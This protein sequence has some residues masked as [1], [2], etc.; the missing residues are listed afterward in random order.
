MILYMDCIQY[1]EIDGNM[2]EPFLLIGKQGKAA[3]DILAARQ[4]GRC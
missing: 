3:H 2:Q 1:K 4:T